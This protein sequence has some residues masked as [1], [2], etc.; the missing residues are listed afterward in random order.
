MTADTGDA[1][2]AAWTF[3]V[4]L[5][6]GISLSTSAAVALSRLSPERSGVGSAL[7]QTVTKLGPA[8]GAAILGSVLNSIYQ[9]RL[10]LNGLPA[11]A[12]DAV[13][14]SVF[15]GIA[16]AQRLHSPALFDNVRTAFVAGMDS[17]LRV[18]AAI[19]VA[20]AVLALAFLPRRAGVAERVEDQL[21]SPTYESS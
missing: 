8:F 9:A 21:A 18:S 12:A 11:P 17:G 19:A 4:G 20:G 10:N 5:G 13:R 7:M 14:R 1:F 2:I 15:A 3:T 16:V 6:A